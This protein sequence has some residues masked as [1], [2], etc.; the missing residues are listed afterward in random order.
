MLFCSFGK[1][2]NWASFC[3]KVLFQMLPRS[4][5]DIAF[6]RFGKVTN[7]ASFCF[8]YC[9][10]AVS[11]EQPRIRL[12]PYFDLSRGSIPGRQP[13]TCV[14]A[15]RTTVPLERLTFGWCGRRETL[16]PQ[17]WIIHVWGCYG[18]LHYT[19]LLYPS[20]P[21]GVK[22]LATARGV[23]M[24]KVTFWIIHQWL[25]GASSVR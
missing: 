18:T 10:C 24:M 23:E 13:C 11:G 14:S 21:S 17:G 1:V 5:S 22:V 15:D 20:V 7:W 9:L 4:V 6:V 19:S 2:A 3:V 25:S 12:S 8:R 16:Q